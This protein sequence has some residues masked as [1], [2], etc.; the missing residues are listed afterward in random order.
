MNCELDADTKLPRSEDWRALI[1]LP[2]YVS[3]IYDFRHN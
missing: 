3:R 2:T 1:T